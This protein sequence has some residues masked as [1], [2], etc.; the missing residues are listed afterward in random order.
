M[1][2]A[3][4]QVKEK[5]RQIIADRY[6]DGLDYRELAAKH[7][8]S[9]NSIGVYLKRGLDELRQILTR[10]GSAMKEIQAALR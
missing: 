6:F 5:H 2:S 1:R 8:L 9:E 3:L 7:Q 10:D 4:A